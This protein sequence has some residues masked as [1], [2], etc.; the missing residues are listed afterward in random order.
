MSSGKYCCEDFY[1]KCPAIKIKLLDSKKGKIYTKEIDL[2]LNVLCDYGCGKKAKYQFKNGKYCCCKNFNSCDNYNLNNH[3]SLGMKM[4]DK[5][6]ERRREIMLN[7][8][9]NYLNSL[10]RDPMKIEKL[11]HFLRQEM[12]NGKSTYLNSIPRNPEKMKNLWPDERREN[13]RQIMLNGGA[14]KALKGIKKISK[15]EKKLGEMVKELYPM[16]EFQHPVFN[17]A[18]DVALTDYKIAIEY[19]GYYHFYTEQAI[20]YFRNRQ[21]KIEEAGWKFIRYTMFDKFPS[22]EKLKNDILKIIENICKN[23]NKKIKEEK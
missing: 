4:T 17:Y 11:K 14:T 16:C 20:M 19:D 1:S 6:C 5:F 3:R 23:L 2:N 18:L 8:Q 10:P 12:L 15:Q 7:G 13:Q 22:L 9:A 21:E